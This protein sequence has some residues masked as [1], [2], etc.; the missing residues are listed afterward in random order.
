MGGHLGDFKRVR[1]NFGTYMNQGIYLGLHYG[2]ESNDYKT[3]EEFKL[4]MISKI[5]QMIITM[6]SPKYLILKIVDIDEII[7]KA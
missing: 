2:D 4:Y 1:S 5:D 6:K 7:H 3:I